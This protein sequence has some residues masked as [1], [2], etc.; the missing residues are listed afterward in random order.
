MTLDLEIDIVST[1]PVREHAGRILHA[2][3]EFAVDPDD[4]QRG[5]HNLTG[6]GLRETLQSSQQVDLSPQE[7]NDAVEILQQNGYVQ[8]IRTLGTAPYRFRGAELTSK[9]R[10]EY[11]QS[12][13]RDQAAGT[14]KAPPAEGGGRIFLGHGR[15]QEWRILKDFLQDRLGLEWDEFNREPTAGLS[16]KER[17]EKMLKQASFAFLVMT[18]EDERADGSKVARASVIHEVGLFQGRLGFERAIV[19]LEQGCEEFSNIVGTTQIRFP[20]GAIASTFEEI[21]RVLEREGVLPRTSGPG[22]PL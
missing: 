12:I 4:R 18:A 13:A 19:L 15:S 5:R 21:R 1:M 7:I 8:V 20:P 10:L 3:A 16:T 6:E 22:L 14:A 9:G 11:E 17:L 2:L